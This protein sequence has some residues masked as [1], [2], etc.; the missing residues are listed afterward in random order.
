MTHEELA[1]ARILIIDD[2]EPNVRVLD[3]LLRRA[4]YERLRAT[5][6]PKQGVALAVEF[7]PDL[8]LLDLH[9]PELDGFDVLDAL[10]AA[11]PPDEYLPVLVLTGDETRQVKQRALA[12][13]AKDFLTKPF[14]PTETLLRI[15]NLL[16][17]RLLHMEL[18]RQNERL[19]VRVQERTRELEAARFEILDR[20]ARAAEYRDDTTGEHTQR[21][22]R[23]AALVAEA[24]GLDAAEVEL[25]RLAAPLHDIGKI[26]IP[27]R[28]LLKAGRLTPEEFEIMKSHTEI[29]GQILSGSQIPVLVRAREIALTH[30]ARWD[31]R[32]YPWGLA[33]EAIPHSGRIVALADVFDALTH[34]RPYKPAW[35][36]A[37]AFDEVRR[38][39]G[40][41]FDPRAAAA[42]GQVYQAG[43]ITL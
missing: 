17:T 29:G 31:G 42:F 24:L 32:G 26:G 18:R 13:G 38:Q 41:H 10:R 27:D 40:G 11:H 7:E 22:G 15:R 8:V 36:P 16:E 30:H 21:V 39:A 9:M 19:E 37:E 4:G 2:Q 14:Q 3:R 23:T 25:I 34:V 43:H 33:G 5:T 20:L 1:Q 12:A 28:I 6:D 35:T